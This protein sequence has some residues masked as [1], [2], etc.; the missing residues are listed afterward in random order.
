LLLVEDTIQNGVK[1]TEW[2]DSNGK[3]MVKDTIQN[4][5]KHFEYGDWLDIDDRIEEIVQN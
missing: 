1:H 4:G 3:V 5:V 2:S